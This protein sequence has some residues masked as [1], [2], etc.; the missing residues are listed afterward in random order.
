MRRSLFAAVSILAIAATPALAQETR[1]ED[2]RTTPIDT[3]TAGNIVI[4]QTG[5]VV[6]TGQPGPAVRL[7]SDNSVT[8]NVGANIEVIDEDGAIGIQADPGVT[9][10]I[11]HGGAITL[12]DSYEAE[13]EDEDGIPDGPFA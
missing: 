8:T 10:G 12:G 3:A 1:I 7:N 4:A 11:S 5:R 6:L 2:E 9:G 13:D